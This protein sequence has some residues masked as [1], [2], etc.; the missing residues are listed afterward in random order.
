MRVLATI[1]LVLLLAPRALYAVGHERI[2]LDSW[3]YRAV[4][5]F[6]ALGWCTLPEDRPFTRDEFIRLVRAIDTHTPGAALSARDE[7][8]LDRLRQEFTGANAISDPRARYDRALFGADSLVAAEA[9]FDLRAFA[10]RVPFGE[11]EEY[12][13]ASAP[14]AKIHIGDRVTYDVRYQLVFGPEHGERAD[15][16]KPSRRTKSFDG[17]TAEFDRSYVSAV[18]S[19]VELVAGRD[20]VQWGPSDL[21]GGLITPGLRYGID[22]LGGRLRFKAFR[23]DAFQGQLF[24]EPER[25]MAGHRLE[26]RFGRTVVG[27]SETVLYN[28]RGLDMLYF[29]PLA[30]F[31]ANQ[32]NER[33]ND[34]N[35]LWALDVKTNALDGLTL[36]GSV[37]V[38]DF[39]FEREAGFPDK[40]AFDAGF[41]WVPDRPLGLTIR[42][43]YRRVDLYT[44]SHVDS[45]SM[46]VSGA[47][48]LAA[49]DVLLGGV[50]GPDADTW[51][52]DAEVFPRANVA[53]SAGWF[54]ARIGEG[55]DVRGFEQGVDDKNPPFPSGVVDET[56]GFDV[57]ARYELRG[58]SWI[59]ATY[60]HASASNRSNISGNDPKTDAFRL[61]LR[62]DI[63]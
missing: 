29:L 14:T 27:V 37:L 4:E 9:D 26:G 42:G 36:Y 6:E 18:W 3:A 56:F 53:L 59:A 58:D 62:W 46:Y 10:E 20:H 15:D 52:I 25:W 63:P 60:A 55:R 28:S 49:G 57:G 45:L 2:P 35:V 12:F 54:G 34:D 5:R 40:L 39:Q 21:E 41:R 51:R 13:A 31:Y 50:P 8:E 48:D 44:Y 7:Y 23:L 19:Q 16:H 1:S 24:G 38:D 32:F 11:E 33:T 43:R 47:G 61:E 30:W 17:L 22:Q